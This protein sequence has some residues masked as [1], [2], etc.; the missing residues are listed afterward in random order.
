M[1]TERN[2]SRI[3]QR[4]ADLAALPATPASLPRVYEWIAVAESNR[5]DGESRERLMDL[6]EEEIAEYRER[7]RV[8]SRDKILEIVAGLAAKW[9]AQPKTL[10][11]IRAAEGVYQKQ[12]ETIALYE[13]AATSLD[14]A[15]AGWAGDRAVI[16][17]RRPQSPI[18]I[19]HSPAPTA[20]RCRSY[21][22]LKPFFEDLEYLATWHKP[23]QADGSYGSFTAVNERYT[24]AID[25]MV[26]NSTPD[27]RA[28]LEAIPTSFTANQAIEALSSEL[29]GSVTIPDRHAELGEASRI[30]MRSYN[31]LRLARPDLS[32]SVIN[33]HWREVEF[34]GLNAER[35]T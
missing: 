29:F 32:Y 20:S 10:A 14:E 6:S 12:R 4:V 22:G 28:W 25:A 2:L 1:A 35:L 24:D 30:K 3:D 26:T 8:A 33:R 16:V 13:F 5:F 15:F 18:W 31:P 27:I 21:P 7:V 11:G 34:V 23:S 9:D 19:G 17:W